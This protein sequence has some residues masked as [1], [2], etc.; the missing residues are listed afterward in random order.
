VAD[1]EIKRVVEF[2][3]RQGEEFGGAFG[4]ELGSVGHAGTTEGEDIAAPPSGEEP[5]GVYDEFGDD[6]PLYDEAV[7][8][9][10]E[11]KKA[12]ASLLQRRLKVGYARAAR[13]LDSM[14][15]R[16]VV[17]PGEGAKPR[18]VYGVS[19]DRSYDDD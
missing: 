4:G 17:G 14:E 3:V 1:R 10:R 2:L 9:V 16:G 6:D 19:A 15:R 12:S 11:A 8:T 18:E 13:L 5:D 7:R